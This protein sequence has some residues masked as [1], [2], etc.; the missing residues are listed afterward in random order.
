MEY[1]FS[2]KRSRFGIF[3]NFLSKTKLG[4][5]NPN[6]CS[7]ISYQEMKP[8]V[9]KVYVWKNKTI[10]VWK[11]TSPW[12]S[13]LWYG[14]IYNSM[15]LLCKSTVYLD[16]RSR[17]LCSQLWRTSSRKPLQETFK[18]SLKSRPNSLNISFLP[19]TDHTARAVERF[20][21]PWDKMHNTSEAELWIKFLS[22]FMRPLPPEPWG[23]LPPWAPQGALPLT[24]TS[25]SFSTCYALGRI[26]NSSP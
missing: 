13:R 6:P 15:I 10:A 3:R 16:D 11:A 24:M 1:T 23:K 25:T 17:P 5:L 2:T 26:K 21:K 7:E 4:V 18:T 22:C 12:I 19:Y 9:E 14:Q 20:G 8:S